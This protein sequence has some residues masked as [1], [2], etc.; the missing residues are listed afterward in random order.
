MNWSNKASL[1]SAANNGNVDMKETFFNFSRNPSD[2]HPAAATPVQSSIVIPPGKRAF[3]TSRGATMFRLVYLSVLLFLLVAHMDCF[4]FHGKSS[5]RLPSS[6]FGKRPTPSREFQ[7]GGRRTKEPLAP[8]NEQIR[9]IGTVRVIGPA[10]DDEDET[11]ENMLGI[12]DIDEA[13]EMAAQMELDLVLIND[14]GDPPVCKIIDYG[15]YRY[16]MEKKKKEN[17]KKQSKS[18]IK[19]VKMSYKIDQHD[20]DVRL[21]NVQRFLK[22]GDRVK[23]I[24]QFKGREM[25]HKEL[26]RE[27]LERIYKPIESE[28]TLESNPRIEGRSIAMLVGPKKKE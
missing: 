14:K 7:A 12:F 16:Q 22:G 15:K 13:K 5:Y 28:A 27:L 4:C 6:L 26:G 25:Q 24:I 23:V 8:I 10:E 17:M 21:R 11:K 18:E 3:G 1:I 19:E 2:P 9:G 20:F